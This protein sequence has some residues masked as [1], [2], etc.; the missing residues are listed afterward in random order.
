MATTNCGKNQVC[1][2]SAPSSGKEVG[3]K[4]GNV[5]SKHWCHSMPHVPQTIHQR[6][7]I[8]HCLVQNFSSL[9]QISQGNGAPHTALICPAFLALWAIIANGQGGHCIIVFQARNFFFMFWESAEAK[10]QIERKASWG[11]PLIS[12][13]WARTPNFWRTKLARRT[14]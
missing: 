11:Q 2:Q 4:I 12:R 6:P 14:Q 3:F 9:C 7:D 13:H 5:D 8:W 10:L 1:A